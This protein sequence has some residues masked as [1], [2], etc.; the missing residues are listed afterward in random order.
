MVFLSRC[1]FDDDDDDSSVDS[2]LM[3]Q[4]RALER[5]KSQSI[6]CYATELFS[7]RK[8]AQEEEEDC[9]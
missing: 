6:G 7:K 2:E 9:C 4:N 5:I 8:M 1:D 3:E